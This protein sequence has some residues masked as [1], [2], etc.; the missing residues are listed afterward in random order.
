MIIKEH[1]MQ[2]S[3]N[4]LQFYGWIALV[5]FFITACNQAVDTNDAISKIAVEKQLLQLIPAKGL[6][7]YKNEPFTGTSLEH[8]KNGQMAVSIDYLNG[9]KEG[10]Y[11]KW[12]G[13]G[14][15]S[16]E[17]Q[18]VVGRKDGESKSW[19]KNGHLRS[20]ANFENGVA[21]GQQKQ[22][23]KSGAKFKVIQLVDGKEKGLQQ[24]WRENGKIYNNYE[25]KNGRIFGLKRANLCY[26]LDD[27]VI[28]LKED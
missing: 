17:S 13:D 19:W 3:K 26:A 8:Y 9:K 1:R 22:W 14:Q 16:F 15:L 28:Q 20:V 21:Q 6:V 23:Y 25:A 5:F 12:F 27:E 7:F 2:F 4:S 18:Y 10:F 24:S 11:K